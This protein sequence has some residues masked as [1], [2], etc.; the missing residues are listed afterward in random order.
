M[1]ECKHRNCTNETAECYQWEYCSSTC[2]NMTLRR[3][4]NELTKKVERLEKALWDERY[5]WYMCT[6][7]GME[8]YLND[9][10][11]GEYYE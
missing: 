2:E 11:A 9:L 7:K 5:K 8:K 6:P 1:S 4:N 3:E 10:Y